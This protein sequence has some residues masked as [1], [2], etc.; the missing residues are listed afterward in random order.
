MIDL[1]DSS[2]RNKPFGNERIKLDENSSA[3]TSERLQ[4]KIAP[5]K[6]LQR[7]ELSVMVDAHQKRAVTLAPKNRT[8]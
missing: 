4:H 6:I 2:L 5:Q 1:I 3:S 7:K 8:L